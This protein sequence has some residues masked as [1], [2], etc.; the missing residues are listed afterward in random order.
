MHTVYLM[1]VTF[2][3]PNFGAVTPEMVSEFDRSPYSALAVPVVDAYDT[4]AVPSL[5]TLQPELAEIKAHTSKHIW[6]WVF[7]NRMVG[8]DPNQKNPHA[9]TSYFQGINGFDLD[10]RIGAQSDFLRTWR[11]ALE[12]AHE[13]HSPGV[14]CDLE[15]YNNYAAND[16]TKLAAQTG[17][18]PEE[19]IQL[20][21]AVGVRMADIADEEL[22]GGTV[23]F[24]FTGLSRPDFKMVN[25][26][27]Y[28]RATSY[29]VLGM[30][31]RIRQVGMKVAVISGGETSLQYCH[32][33]LKQ[34]QQDIQTRLKGFLPKLEVYAGILTL[35]GPIT[36]WKDKSDKSAWLLEGNCGACPARNVEELEPYLRE[37]LQTYNHVWVYAPAG[38]GG[39]NPFDTSVAPRFNKVLEQAEKEAASA[40]Q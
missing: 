7:F 12:I 39:Y 1:L 5:Q 32:P 17:K 25:G 36:L 33:S 30:L 35:G 27:S 15:L 21:E 11:V 13:A 28:Y 10:D 23:W 6:P 29:V 24:F 9:Q 20:L 38:P 4:G 14:V 34:L 22:P 18:N 16:V 2:L 26:K 8:S 37:L 40:K 19:V 31:Q 3:V